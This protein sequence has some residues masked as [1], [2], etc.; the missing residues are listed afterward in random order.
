[1][2]DSHCHIDRIK[3]PESAIEESR[4]K[5]I[6]AIVTSA[7]SLKEA[8][9][10]LALK[11]KFSDILYVCLGVHPIEVQEY[12]DDY[13][14]YIRER[15]SDI[16]AIGEIGLDGMKAGQNYDKTSDVFDRMLTLA[17]ELKLPVVIHSRNGE[18]KAISD[19]I[20]IL[21]KS[22]VKQVMMHCF[23]GNETNLKD[24]LDFGYHISYATN[25][26]WTKKHPVL[27]KQ[28]PLDR[29]LLETDSPWLDPDSR[30]DNIKLDNRP[31]KITK[32]AEIIAGVKNISKEEVL[33]ITADNARKFFNIRI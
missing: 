9:K 14:N 7:L 23:S 28:T 5:G 33:K 13:I 2:I 6:T 24:A 25:I 15:N 1:L 29:M 12:N 32:S 11:K 22:N 17:N 31:W 20:R 10:V 3:G 16:V 30:I 21:S 26:C 27:A 19:V 8:E 18:K 4:N